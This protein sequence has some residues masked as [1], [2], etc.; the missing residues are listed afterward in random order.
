MATLP[1][2]P[3][4]VSLDAILTRAK[5]VAAVPAPRKPQPRAHITSATPRN[6]PLGDDNRPLLA[7]TDE[8]AT[9]TGS[10]RAV[11]LVLPVSVLTCTCGAVHR[12][13]AAYVL[14]KY[15]ANAHA[16]HYSRAELSDADRALPRETREHTLSITFCEECF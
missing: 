15:A 8:L 16:F 13:P 3:T 14:A 9:D 5:A 12:V 2:A 6:A 10:A 4:P 1:A 7:L 11:A